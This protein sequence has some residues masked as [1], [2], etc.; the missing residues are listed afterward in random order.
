VSGSVRDA[1]EDGPVAGT[2]RD[3]DAPVA[4]EPRDAG[5]DAAVRITAQAKAS[6]QRTPDRRLREIMSCLV[7]H[8]HAFIVQTGLRE[9]E[10]AQAISILT[11]TGA[12]T[13][14]RRQEFILFSDALGVSM[15]VDALSHRLPSGATESTVLGPFYVPGAPLRGYGE[16]IAEREAGTPAWVA[17][18]VL[19]LTGEPIAGAELDVW[20]NGANRLYAVQDPDAPDDHLRGRFIT[21]DDG[22]FAFTAVRPVAYQIPT[23]GPVGRMLTATARSAWRPAHIHLIVRAEG[24]QTLTTHIF[25]ADSEHLDDDAVF[26]VKPSLVHRFRARAADDPQRPATIHGPW[27]SLDLELTLAPGSGGEVVDH[28]RTH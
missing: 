24:Y 25:D 12:I 26:A 3:A 5:G 1:G 16:S 10:W 23:D 6:F 27:V 28:G 8:L 2:A 7:E 20:Q 18:R 13:D 14:E 11:A 15:L 4:G 22:R 17:G 9:D 19:S 21:G